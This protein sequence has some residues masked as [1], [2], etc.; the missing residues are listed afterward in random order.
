M[1][2]MV[3]QNTANITSSSEDDYVNNNNNVRTAQDLKVVTIFPTKM[4][5]QQ[6]KTP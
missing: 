1:N 6:L 2:G 4:R 5:N 3:S